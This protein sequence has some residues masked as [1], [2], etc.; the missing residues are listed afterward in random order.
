MA[1]GP[2]TQAQYVTEFLSHARPAPCQPACGATLSSPSHLP[3]KP[4]PE[5]AHSLL[6][7]CLIPRTHPLAGWT[8]LC[9]GSFWPASTRRGQWMCEHGMRTSWR[10][11]GDQATCTHPK[12]LTYVSTWFWTFIS[13]FICPHDKTARAKCKTSTCLSWL[14]V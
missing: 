5:L 7:A 11:L 8:S 3:L 4:M 10:Y 9:S 12:P 1:W 6:Q 14:M 2:V 13:C